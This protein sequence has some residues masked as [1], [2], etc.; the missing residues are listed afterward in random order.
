MK[1][2]KSLAFAVTLSITSGSLFAATL[3]VNFD[4]GGLS[5]RNNGGATPITAGSPN[6]NFDGGIIQL[7]YFNASSDNN[8]FLGTFIPLSGEGSTNFVSNTVFDTTVG[9]DFNQGFGPPFDGQ[10]QISLT[11]NDAQHSALPAT[12]T[13]LSIRIYNQ[14]SIA[15]SSH[16]MTLSNNSWKWKDLKSGVPSPTDAV[17]ISFADP[18][19]L[20]Q[21]NRLGSGGLTS[22]PGG[23]TVS[24]DPQANIAIVPEPTS[25][26]LLML[27]LVS[28]A[29]RRRRAAKV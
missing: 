27:G 15:A 10:F 8:N 28:L 29:S 22:T 16:F 24:G 21:E 5:V 26:G 14:T 25:A 19:V 17:N 18:G 4:S 3:A 23:T 12:G 1:K 13:V 9:D 7:G 2:F 11:Y 20:R 6:V